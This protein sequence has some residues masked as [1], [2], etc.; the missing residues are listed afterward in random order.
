MI[1][2]GRVNIIFA[3]VQKYE[4]RG[5]AFPIVVLR[6]IEY[7]SF[8][9][10]ARLSCYASSSGTVGLELKISLSVFN[11]CIYRQRGDP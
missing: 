8:T 1:G 5:I 4:S 6:V 3:D 10:N 9:Q 11:G 7:G 2:I